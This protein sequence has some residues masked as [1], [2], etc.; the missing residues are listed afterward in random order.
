M[1]TGKAI[2]TVLAGVAV[3]ATLGVLF[4]PDKGKNTRKKIIKQKDDYVAGLENKFN[5]FIGDITQKF[6]AVKQE[7][8]RLTANGKAKVEELEAELMTKKT[9]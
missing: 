2:L 4:A 5:E 3:G 1:N 7:A 6:E 8:T 9:K